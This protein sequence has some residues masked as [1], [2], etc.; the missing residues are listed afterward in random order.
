MAEAGSQLTRHDLEAKI[1]KRS[2]E[3]EG[4][5]REF[6]ADP[7]GVFAR[8]LQIPVVSLPKV[9]VHDNDCNVDRGHP[10]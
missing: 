9:V 4:F 8:Y 3:D 7:V 2:W 10:G 5:R 1:V 6:L